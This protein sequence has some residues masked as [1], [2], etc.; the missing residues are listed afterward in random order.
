MRIKHYFLY[1]KI[2]IWDISK[3]LYKY[4][5]NLDGRVVFTKD[6]SYGTKDKIEPG[7]VIYFVNK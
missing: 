7:T 1:K 2:Q 6:K 3:L 5:S 4:E